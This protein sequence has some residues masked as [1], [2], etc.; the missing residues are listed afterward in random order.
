MIDRSSLLTSRK[1]VFLG[2]IL[3]STVAIAVF[4]S[5]G[6]GSKNDAINQAGRSEKDRPSIAETKDIA[7]QGFI[8]GLPL[9]MNYVIMNAYSINRD[10]PA[11]TAPLNQILNEP[12]VHTPKDRAIPLPNS[13]T[14]YSVLFMDLRAEPIVL[15]LPAVEKG[16]YYSVM[17]SDGN[18][19]NYGYMG[20]RT[21]G[22]DAG[23][24]MVVGPDWKG[25]TPKGIKKVFQ[26]S[27][28]FSLAAYRT[29]L[30]NAN[31]MDNV[32]KVQA[33]YKVQTLSAY[34]KQPP[35]P[36]APTLDWPKINKEMVK[37]NFFEYLNFALQFAPELPEEKEVRAKLARIGI[38]P[39][40]TFEIKDL[41]VEHKAAVLLG[42]KEGETKVD[43]AIKNFG[44]NINGWN[45]A[46]IFG[47][48]AFYN[49]DWLKRAAAA[50]FGIFG[51]SAEEALYPFVDKDAN[52]ETLDGS[53]HNYT[54][55][56]AA[57][58]FPPV[59]AF[60]SLTM[61][62][63]KTQQ[64]I[65]NPINRYLLNSEMLPMMKK[66]PDGSLT[67]YIQKDS[68]RKQKESNWLPSPNGPI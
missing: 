20:T 39:G 35:P 10:S 67:I 32:K 64:I 37:T 14:P 62:D 61:Y 59:Q 15:S 22:N 45:V 47:D 51:N 29:Q 28:Q 34:L 38:G 17:L 33:G 68:P 13:D 50:K 27:Y 36:A 40:K 58:Q 49:G 6:C 2:R 24:Y 25:E 57:N 7:E 42:M 56:F 21:I 48:R 1:R 18:T 26:S 44:K 9:V 60:W 30:L 5:G 12:R 4:L 41:S 8:Y 3:P 43:N 66:N 31:D 52:G 11:F 54:L 16:R 55:S 65:D 23:S 46:S 19:Y 63:P 53:K